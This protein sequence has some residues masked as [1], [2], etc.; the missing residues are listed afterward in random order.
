MK[1]FAIICFLL[2]VLAFISATSSSSTQECLTDYLSYK[3]GKALLQTNENIDNAWPNDVDLADIQGIFNAIAQVEM[4]G[5]KLLMKDS[6]DASAQ[7]FG[8]ILSLLANAGNAL[9][10]VGKTLLKKKY[11]PK[12]RSYKPDMPVY[13]DMDEKSWPEENDSNLKALNV[14]KVLFG[15]LKEVE[16]KMSMMQDDAADSKHAKAEAWW[17]KAKQWIN[18][19]VG[20]TVK[21][22]LC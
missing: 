16:A 12:N 18:N 1:V 7:L 21:R 20:G 6:T 8:T 10:G 5:N 15:V 22:F 9:W 17:K 14:L 13:G 19:A 2:P 3:E 11:C 4:E